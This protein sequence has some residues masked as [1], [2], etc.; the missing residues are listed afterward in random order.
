MVIYM[1]AGYAGSGKSTAGDILVAI[2]GA[3]TQRR[4]FGDAV[5]DDVS[6]M[7]SVPRHL[8]DTQ[9]GKQMM[10]ATE[11]GEKTLR[12]LLIAHSAAMKSDTHNAGHWAD[13]VVNSINP[14]FPT[15]IHDWRYVVEYERVKERFQQETIITLRIVRSTVVPLEDP[16]EHDL[17][18]FP[19]TY[20]IHNDGD[21]DELTAALNAIIT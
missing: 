7:Y 14:E 16:S 2:N 1:I 3:T 12:A 15:V 11:D 17:D 21:L 10:W 4:A 6:R 9:E 19:T 18:D 5:K 8:L 20:T 13:L